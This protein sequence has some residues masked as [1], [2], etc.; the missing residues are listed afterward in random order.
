MISAKSLR[1]G[2]FWSVNLNDTFQISPPLVFK[3]KQIYMASMN[4][5]EENIYILNEAVI[6]CKYKSICL[7]IYSTSSFSSFTF[8]FLDS[9]LAIIFN[10]NILLSGLNSFYYLYIFNLYLR[11]VPDGE[12]KVRTISLIELIVIQPHC[13]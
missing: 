3:H 7:L 6:K 10:W 13:I 5:I 9:C 1:I 11:K 4:S 2:L 12:M 8:I